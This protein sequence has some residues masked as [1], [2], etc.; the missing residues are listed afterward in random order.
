[1]A[2]PPRGVTQHHEHDLHLQFPATALRTVPVTWAADDNI[3]DLDTV[4]KPFDGA[5]TSAILR[6]TLI[7][8]SAPIVG[9][10]SPLP[11]RPSRG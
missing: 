3:V 8:P 7:N 5:A 4:P 9:A 2:F 1:M 6:Y 11:A 10:R